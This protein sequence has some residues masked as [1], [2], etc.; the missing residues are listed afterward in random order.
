MNTLPTVSLRRCPENGDYGLA[1][2]GQDCRCMAEHRLHPYSL[3]PGADWFLFGGVAIQADPCDECGG[4]GERT[5]EM[6]PRIVGL[7]E[8]PKCHGLGVIPR[9]G[10]IE[11]RC[12][13]H[14]SSECSSCRVEV[15]YLA[16][17]VPIGEDE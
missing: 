10:L 3:L 14:E 9:H 11:R 13:K 1:G 2:F 8:C 5:V 7:G 16:A 15:T 4:C 17:A 12:V 6:Y